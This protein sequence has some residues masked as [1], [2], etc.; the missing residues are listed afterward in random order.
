MNPSEQM[1]VKCAAVIGVTFT[2]EMLLYILPEWTKRKMYQT[3]A[4][5]VESRIFKCCSERKEMNVTQRMLSKEFSISNNELKSLRQESGKLVIKK[6]EISKT[7]VYSKGMEM[8]EQHYCILCIS[9]ILNW[10]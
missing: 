5:L 8:I 6:L 7:P 9:F 4:A 1:V 2:T 10:C 3:L